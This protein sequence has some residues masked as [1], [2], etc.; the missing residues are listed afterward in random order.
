MKIKFFF[1]INS[2][3]SFQYFFK[4]GEFEYEEIIYCIILEHIDF[5]NS[6]LQ[7]VKVGQ[8]INLEGFLKGSETTTIERVFKVSDLQPNPQFIKTN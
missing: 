6:E 3:Q 5:I 1:G 7:T 8:I 4:Y 2:L